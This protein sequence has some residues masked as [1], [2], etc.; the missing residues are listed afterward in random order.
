ML[1]RFKDESGDSVESFGSPLAKRRK[2]KSQSG[3]RHNV[4]YSGET[5]LNYEI[6]VSLPHRDL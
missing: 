1:Q 4:D 5:Q 2:F 6:F 3:Q